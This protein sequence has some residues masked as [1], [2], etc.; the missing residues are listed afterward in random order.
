MDGKQGNDNSVQ[1]TEGNMEALTD[2]AL[3]S[4]FFWHGIDDS[5]AIVATLDRNSL[6]ESSL[7]S[8]CILMVV[9][10]CRKASQIRSWMA[11]CPCTQLIIIL[12]R[13]DNFSVESSMAEGNIFRTVA[14]K[15]F[16]AWS[17]LQGSI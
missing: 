5:P 11:D 12:C 16:K 4:L 1:Y 9:I 13:N 10:S 7:S 6:R 2:M 8:I 17:G 15:P 14:T 3:G